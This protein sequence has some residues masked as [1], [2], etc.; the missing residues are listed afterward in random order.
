[1]VRPDLT[2][3]D[4]RLI[5]ADLKVLRDVRTYPSAS[6]PTIQSI[7]AYFAAAAQSTPHIGAARWQAFT[8][9]EKRRCLILALEAIARYAHQPL[10]A[11][12]LHAILMCW[13]NI[14]Q[15]L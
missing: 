3:N 6:S 15:R 2:E 13:I 5:L 1:V 9:A 10:H 4:Y 11:L 14:A 8:D 12:Y 7:I